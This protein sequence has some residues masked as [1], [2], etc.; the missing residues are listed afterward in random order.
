M[1]R[2]CQGLRWKDERG[3]GNVRNGWRNQQEE[4]EDNHRWMNEAT[5]REHCCGKM[6]FIER[7]SGIRW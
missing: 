6:E 7:E 2:E 3:E 1:K 4:N 5:V